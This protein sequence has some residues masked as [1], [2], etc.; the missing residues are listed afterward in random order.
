MRITQGTFSFLPDLTDEEIEAQ[1]PYAL[2]Q[3]LGD[4]GRVHR[5]SRI[6]A[7][8]YWEMWGQPDVRPPA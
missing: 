7:T 8:A 6:P 2:A 3:R 1:I 4:H 5:R